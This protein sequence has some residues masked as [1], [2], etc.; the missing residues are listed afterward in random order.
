MFNGTKLAVHNHHEK[1]QELCNK[2]A[3]WLLLAT[4]MSKFK[5]LPPFKGF[6]N[7][8]HVVF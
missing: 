5:L 7:V 6:H 3:L 2:I 8:A 1:F 4:T